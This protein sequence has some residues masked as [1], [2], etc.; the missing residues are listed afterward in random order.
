VA[1][2]ET[3][4]RGRTTQADVERTLG[5]WHPDLL[6]GNGGP[7]TLFEKHSAVSGDVV[8]W[9]VDRPSPLFVPPR[10]LVASFGRDGSLAGWHFESTYPGGRE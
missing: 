2:D 6:R 9:Y 3:L 7:V 8:D 10:Y 1:L 5:R 4:V